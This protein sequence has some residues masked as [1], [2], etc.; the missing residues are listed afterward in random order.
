MCPDYIKNPF[1][2]RSGHK[3]VGLFSDFSLTTLV[4][5]V[6]EKEGM[7]PFYHLYEL[8]Q[9]SKVFRYEHSPLLV[10]GTHQ[11]LAV[12]KCGRKKE[13]STESRPL[14]LHKP[15]FKNNSFFFKD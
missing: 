9:G 12:R 4:S 5:S 11:N 7:L 1:D 2:P 6:E 13:Q 10:Y 14:E 3:E 8:S 15:L